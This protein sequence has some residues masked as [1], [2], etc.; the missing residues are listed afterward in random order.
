MSIVQCPMS[1]VH[2]PAFIVHCQVSNVH[3]CVIQSF[4][5]SIVPLFHR[6]NVLSFHLSI[7][8]LHH[9]IKNSWF[10]Q[11]STT[12]CMRLS[13]LPL[14]HVHCPMCID[15]CSFP[16]PMKRTLLLSFYRFIEEPRVSSKIGLTQ[17]TSYCTI[18]IRFCH[19]G[20]LS[21]SD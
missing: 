5:C 9:S 18:H 17:F 2:C 13:F 19:L 3:H 14:G 15:K 6:S 4:Y 12:L 21:D 10:T 7:V 11:V 1:I 8:V 20:K 16:S